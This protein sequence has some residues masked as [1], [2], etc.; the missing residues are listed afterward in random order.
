[1]EIA[2]GAVA[3]I[4]IGYDQECRHKV[5]GRGQERADFQRP[6]G[7][8]PQLG[9]DLAKKLIEDDKV[10]GILGCYYSAVTK[11]VAAICERFSVPMIND[12]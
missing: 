2:N 6:P 7:H 9:A 10:V 5:P 1:V 4:D 12:Y 3:G 11:T 8:N